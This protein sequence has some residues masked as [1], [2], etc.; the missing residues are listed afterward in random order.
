MGRTGL[1][2]LTVILLTC[3]SKT[4][5]GQYYFRI[6]CD[7]SIK[8][9]VEGGEGTL[10]L[11]RLYYDKSL[12]KMVYDIRFPEREVWVVQD[13]TIYFIRGG[14]IERSR[15]IEQYSQ[16]TVF[17]KILEGQL[18]NYGLQG[19]IFDI[20]EVEREGEMVITTWVPK[21]ARH[22]LGNILTSTVGGSLFGVVFQN[23]AG[24]IIGRQLFRNYQVVRGLSIPSE[25]VQVYYRE[26]R[27]EYQVYSM[28]NIIINNPGNENLYNYPVSGK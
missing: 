10:I 13:T 15:G 16:S 19:T 26:G 21:T 28:S 7:I 18:N 20:G 11:G 24:E 12:Q 25:I 9:K 2:F 6:E 1:I 27:E 8:N 14:N 17:H 3:F 4:S 22:I 5:S 23:P